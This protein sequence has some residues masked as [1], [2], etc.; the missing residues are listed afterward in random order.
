MILSNICLM[1]EDNRQ[2][3][4]HFEEDPAKTFNKTNHANLI[5]IKHSSAFQLY[6]HKRPID[7][8]RQVDQTTLDNQ[9]I[10][11]GMQKSL[12]DIKQLVKPKDKLFRKQQPLRDPASNTIYTFLMSQPKEKGM[13][14]VEWSAFRIAI[15]LLGFTGLRVNE[16]RNLTLSQLLQFRDKRELQFYQAKQNKHRTVY[17]SQEGERVLS[18]LIDEFLI[19]FSRRKTLS[20]GIDHNNWITFINCRLKKAAN[21]FSLNLKSHSFRINFITS[22]LKIAPVQNVSQIIGHQDIRSTMIYNRY[23]ID[24][25]KTIQLLNRGIYKDNTQGITKSPY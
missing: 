1:P 17:L 8:L 19:V 18:L 21:K 7:V 14:I 25:E 12:Q 5:N 13:R 6:N 15:T 24:K 20:G 23:H 10:L 9:D 11:I 2:K 16:I 22:L 3:S 4:M